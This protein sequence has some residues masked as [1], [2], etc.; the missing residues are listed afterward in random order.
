MAARL[1]PQTALTAAQCSR[2]NFR[3]E[4]AWKV[5]LPAPINQLA[6][7]VTHDQF[8]GE[9][10]FR[11]RIDNDGRFVDQ[12]MPLDSHLSTVN[13]CRGLEARPRRPQE[14]GRASCRERV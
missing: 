4:S 9:A 10:G 6:N 11:S 14:I 5:F 12:V 13:V 2:S 7:I 8:I 1:Q 3:P